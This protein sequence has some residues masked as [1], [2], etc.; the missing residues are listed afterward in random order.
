M[1]YFT[2]QQR[3]IFNNSLKNLINNVKPLIQGS[4]F[5]KEQIF[6][7]ISWEGP[8]RSSRILE[9]VSIRCLDGP[10]HL[11]PHLASFF[12]RLLS[13]LVFL[14]CLWGREM[15]IWLELAGFSCS[16][17]ATGEKLT[18]SVLGILSNL[19]Y[20]NWLWW[21]YNYYVRNAGWARF[22]KTYLSLIF[23]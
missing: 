21:V 22:R 12:V 18:L 16:S 5:F 9:R 1:L 20:G 10:W 11:H 8:W 6:H 7:Q 19:T 17:C 13:C 15:G 14:Q 4:L 2:S 3:V 23:S